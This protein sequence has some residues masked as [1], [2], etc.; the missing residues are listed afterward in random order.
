MEKG[1]L[2]E[3]RQKQWRAALE[4]YIWH[5]NSALPATH[6]LCDIETEWEKNDKG[7]KKRDKPF[8]YNILLG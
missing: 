7:K 3:D 2:E 1:R 5:P 4:V 8:P 6:A